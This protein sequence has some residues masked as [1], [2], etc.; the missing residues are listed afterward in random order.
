MYFHSAQTIEC[1]FLLL[2]YQWKIKYNH[3]VGVLMKPM[4]FLILIS[5]QCNE[6]KCFVFFFLFFSQEKVKL[7]TNLYKSIYEWHPVSVSVS[8]H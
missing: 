5:K 6:R 8:A 1:P 3:K 2:I 4:V 7:G